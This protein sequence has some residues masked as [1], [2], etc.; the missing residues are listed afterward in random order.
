MRNFHDEKNFFFTIFFFYFYYNSYLSLT[1]N[2]VHP[3]PEQ[4]NNLKT[5]L[6]DTLASRAEE[7]GLTLAEEI[8]FEKAEEGLANFTQNLFLKYREHFPRNQPP[9][10]LHLLCEIQQMISKG[11]LPESIEN[12]SKW[13]KLAIKSN[14]KAK[15]T[16]MRS[17]RRGSDGAG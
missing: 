13:V 7:P 9:K 4:L 8:L 5:F 15:V 11:G 12:I 3:R 17:V 6:F 14:F 1:H 10:A 16:A 2:L